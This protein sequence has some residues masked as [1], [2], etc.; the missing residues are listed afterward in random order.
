MPKCGG[1]L[2]GRDRRWVAIDRRRKKLEDEVSRMLRERSD[3]RRFWVD[4]K[5]KRCEV[6]SWCEDDAASPVVGCLASC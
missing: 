6:V 4:V 5:R 3:I 1:K 2:T